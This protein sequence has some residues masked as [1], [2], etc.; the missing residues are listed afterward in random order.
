MTLLMILEIREEKVLVSREVI[1]NNESGLH[2]RPAALFVQR[3]N[4][5]ESDIFVELEDKRADAKSIIGVMSLG[6][7]SG[8]R[9]TLNADGKDEDEAIESLKK[10]LEEEM[11]GM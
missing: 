10:L 11:I 6:A 4:K 8:E 1:V 2:A 9:I 5:F 3:A 7:Y